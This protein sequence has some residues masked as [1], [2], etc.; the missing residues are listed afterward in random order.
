MPH[1]LRRLLLAVTLSLGV[2]ALAQ[3]ALQPQELPKLLQDWL[4]WAW[5][6]HLAERCPKAFDG[7]VPQPCVWPALLELKA[8]ASGASFRFEVH[9]Y[10]PPA[11]VALPAKATHLRVEPGAEGRRQRAH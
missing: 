6:G 2:P 8:Q 10:G 4:P 1:F 9:V 7:Q 11:R 3:P 5:H